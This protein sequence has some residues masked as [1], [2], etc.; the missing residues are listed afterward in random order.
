[1]QLAHEALLCRWK[2]M[3]QWLEKDW[4]REQQLR[5]LEEWA[6]DWENHLLAEDRGASYLLV[7]NRL[8][9]AKGLRE[10]LGGELPPRSQR[11]LDASIAAEVRR[12]EEEWARSEK[13]KETMRALAEAQ[14]RA[15]RVLRVAF[16]VAV[17]LLVGA[18]IAV[19]IVI[20]L[21]REEKELRE[22]TLKTMQ[23]LLNE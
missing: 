16:A 23:M 11:L 21:L 1:V 8:G 10:R 3:E 18:I 6:E 2:R 5:D 22:M 12:H 9:Y 4:E 19:I 14:A 13:E 17:V 7:G 15:A 20:L